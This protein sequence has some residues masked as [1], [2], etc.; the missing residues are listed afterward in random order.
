M[1]FC[2]CLGGFTM[3][4]TGFFATLLL[5]LGIGTSTALFL[6]KKRESLSAIKFS[7]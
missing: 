1:N 3:N 5:I 2:I 4:K 7:K 6:K